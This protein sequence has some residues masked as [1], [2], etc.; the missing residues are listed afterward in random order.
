GRFDHRQKLASLAVTFEHRM[1][2]DRMTFDSAEGGPHL[3]YLAGRRRSP[4]GVDAPRRVDRKIIQT[5]EL[6]A[7]HG[8]SVLDAQTD[9]VTAPDQKKADVAET[10]NRRFRLVIVKQCRAFLR[11]AVDAA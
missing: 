3:Q 9:A 7:R 1:P 10:D 2:R 8:M 11:F 4:F 6:L 5:L